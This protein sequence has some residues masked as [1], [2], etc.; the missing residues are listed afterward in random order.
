[1]IWTRMMHM[2]CARINAKEHECIIYS[3]YIQDKYIFI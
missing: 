1:M 2:T 3:R